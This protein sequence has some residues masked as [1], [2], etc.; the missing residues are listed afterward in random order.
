MTMQRTL[1]S[2]LRRTLT[3]LALLGAIPVGLHAQETQRVAAVVNEDV[4]SLHD[5]EQR[6]R[7][8]ILSSSMP[9]T[10]ESRQ[11]VASQVL[12]L[13]IDERLKIQ[14]AQRLKV[15]VSANEIGNGI[16]TIERQNKMPRGSF[17][18]YLKSKGVDPET[19]H[20]QIRAELSWVHV[21]RRELVPNLRIGEEEIT[22]RLEMLKANLGKPEYLAA[23]I[24]LPVEN[25]GRDEETRTLA[26]KLL[27]Q[28]KQ[29]AQFSALARQFSQSG[30]SAGGDL[31]WISNGMLD[32]ELMAPL[33]TMAPG[34]ITQP[35]RLVDGYHILLLREKRL[36]GEGGS[37]EPSL[38]IA[39]IFLTNLPGTTQSQVQDQLKQLKDAIAGAK[40][41]DDFE[42]AS[43]KIHTAEWSRPGVIKPSELPREV[44]QVAVGLKVGE[45][46][47][48]LE[49]DGSRR[50]FIMCAR[51]E[52][53]EGG[54]PSRDDMRKRI[55]DERMEIMA[56]RYL[57]DLRRSAFVEYR[58]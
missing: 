12:R 41:C 16:A 22:A 7:L 24:V 55:E 46:S 35:I 3:A 17:E 25:P 4:V 42:K 18:P 40:T 53:V 19:I 52:A 36:A 33:E 23:E 39:Q 43:R 26:L 1:S 56:K 9:D 11:R 50:L 28:L 54:L 49:M 31:G 45:V 5:L 13:L 57:R 30:G 8:A 47:E 21:V 10:M 32:D 48:P 29:G 38:D 51:T 20:Q 6:M 2:F 58:M 34:N 37:T 14:E 44:A 15:T 27:D